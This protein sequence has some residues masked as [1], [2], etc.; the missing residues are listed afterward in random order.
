MSLAFPLLSVVFTGISALIAFLVPI[1][2]AV[3]CCR[4]SR[5]ALLS[6]S[7]GAVCF[8]VGAML[9]E[10]MFHQLVFS[11]V[12]GIA[13]NLV[14]Y[15][16]YG[17]LAAGLFEETA[18]LIGL[19]Y[20]CKKDASPTTGFAYGVG[21]GGIEAILLVGVSVANNLVVMIMVNG[22]SVNAL[23]EG[24]TDEQASTA[25][26]QLEQL[27]AQPSSVF[28][29]AGVE[30]IIAICLHLALS[31]LIWM[32]VTQ[33]LPMWGYP[34]AIGLHAVSN[35]AAGLYQFGVIGIWT[36]EVITA[37][38]VVCICLLVQRFYRSRVSTAA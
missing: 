32:V 19:R 3:H 33:K 5:N 24:A 38:V 16:L 36:S 4:R 2:L 14:L 13:Q 31:M 17:C 10:S 35:I 29:A 9:L 6:I 12:P 18:R 8:L 7:V 27:A 23:L 28:L 11:L 1:V 25:M 30:R 15:C 34:L 20:L 22:G 37:A 21:H 26:A